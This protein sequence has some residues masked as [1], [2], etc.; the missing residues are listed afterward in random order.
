MVFKL[1]KF[2]DL[3]KMTQFEDATDDKATGWG[4]TSSATNALRSWCWSHKRNPV[5]VLWE[6]LHKGELCKNVIFHS[7]LIPEKEMCILFHSYLSPSAFW[8]TLLMMVVIIFV[9]IPFSWT[10]WIYLGRTDHNFDHNIFHEN[11]QNHHWHLIFVQYGCEVHP[12]QCFHLWG[13]TCQ[14][15]SNLEKHST[16]QW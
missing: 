3:C 4:W 7:V 10:T 6:L 15:S 14:W 12:C 1:L 11:D 8:L 16:W 9:I 2:S 5:S 13:Q